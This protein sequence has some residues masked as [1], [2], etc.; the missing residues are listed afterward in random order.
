MLLYLFLI[1]VVGVLAV[2]F[3]CDA[4]LPIVFLPY[5]EEGAFAGK[6]V[7]ITGASSGIGASLA[8][9][10]VRAGAQVVISARREAALEAVADKCALLGT[11]PFVLPLDVTDFAAQ[12][13]AVKVV[14]EKFGR[15]DSLVLNAGMAQRIP[16]EKTDL[17]VTQELMHL[18]FISIV[19]LTKLVL[20]SMLARGAGQFVIMSSVSGIIGTPLGSSYS[21]SKFA[22][23]GYFNALRA[24]VGSRGVG[25]TIICPGP[26]VSEIADKAH[27]NSELPAGVET[28]AKM[29]TA[30]CT[31]YVAK[32]MYY[33][34]YEAWL[35]QQ[36]VL[37][38]TYVYKYAPFL[39]NLLA[40]KI[41]GPGRVRAFETGGDIYD[42]KAIFTK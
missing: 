5:K 30:R 26:V 7:W 8:E 32:A 27:R 35:S 3:Q 40:V 29:P 10:M 19:S 28:E 9:D 22:L 4:D 2:F 25:V 17:Q 13:E 37:A 15:V 6:T 36:P 12:A 21:A 11:R 24:E 16:A 18:N 1:V 39:A 33:G 31:G 38:F 23:H 42:M 34:F 41:F 20:P 14:M